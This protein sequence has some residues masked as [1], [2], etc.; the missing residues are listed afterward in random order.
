MPKSEWKAYYL[1]WAKK[2]FQLAW[3]YVAI[4][5][6][7]FAIAIRYGQDHQSSWVP[8]V[9]HWAWL[10]PFWVFLVLAILGIFI[11]PYILHKED[12]AK[13]DEAVKELETK[14]TA[15]PDI[16]SR[17]VYEKN[18]AFL[19]VTNSGPGAEIWVPMKIEGMM[20]RGNLDNVFA[21]WTH[22][23]SVK[24]KIAKDQTCRL[25][26]ASLD[27]DHQALMG[28]WIVYWTTEKGPLEDRPIYSMLLG[29]ADVQTP[30][31]HIFVDVVSDP[32]NISGIK[33]H[34]VA[35]HTRK[36]EEV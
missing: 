27:I 13:A 18:E 28:R 7:L 35:L 8:T 15:K 19:E 33:K 30:D 5:S 9:N 10:V 25:K 2:V 6:G 24:T 17:F 32:D 26:I 29:N 31:I 22:T 23:N 34:H 20:Q 11:A 1:R 21:R 16:H 3:S 36:A 12:K 4:V 14:I